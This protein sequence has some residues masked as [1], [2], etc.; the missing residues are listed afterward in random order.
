MPGIRNSSVLIH[1][2]NSITENREKY[3]TRSGI[4]ARAGDV[5]VASSKTYRGIRIKIH[6][7][8]IA[9]VTKYISGPFD[10]LSPGTGKYAKYI[11][12]LVLVEEVLTTSLF[13]R[14]VNQ[15]RCEDKST[16]RVT[17]VF[18]YATELNIMGIECP[19]CGGLQTRLDSCNCGY[20]RKGDEK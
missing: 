5:L 13:L 18:S 17:T 2:S 3:G 1:L 12:P 15:R 11:A 19:S 20:V 4:G 14:R 6:N 9:P 10:L 7:D 8:Q 16:D